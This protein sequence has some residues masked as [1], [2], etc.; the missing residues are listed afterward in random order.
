MHRVIVLET[1]R[2]FF[3][4]LL[5]KYNEGLTPLFTAILFKRKGAMRLLVELHPELLDT[6]NENGC[7]PFEYAE[8]IEAGTEILN[9]L[10]QY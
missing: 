6:P 2:T 8:A 3:P 5:E 1:W 10:E 9:F 7:T 4:I